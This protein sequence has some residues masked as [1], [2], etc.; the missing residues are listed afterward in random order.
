INQAKQ[1]IADND[2]EKADSV[3]I[4]A[5]ADGELALAEA[6]ETQAQM[7][8]LQALT[9]IGQMSADNNA[10][11]SSS[12]TTTSAVIQTSPPPPT[13]TVQTTTTTTGGGK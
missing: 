6:R 12:V 3:L 4:R 7:A 9:A 13:T 8:A 2:N 1:L 11:G 5:K 10:G